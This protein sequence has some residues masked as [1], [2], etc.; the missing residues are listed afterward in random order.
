[1][2]SI[3][4][5]ICLIGEKLTTFLEHSASSSPRSV[6]ALKETWENK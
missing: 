1:M 4:V 3:S 6:S 2:L 5:Y